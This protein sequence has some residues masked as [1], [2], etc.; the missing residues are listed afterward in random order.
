MRILGQLQELLGGGSAQQRALA[1]AAR[2]NDVDALAKM[3]AS[4]DD[5]QLKE[6]VQR[7]SAEQAPLILKQL[8][9]HRKVALTIALLQQRSLSPAAQNAIA[10]RLT[11][12]ERGQ[13]LSFAGA[14]ARTLE[15]NGFGAGVAA[16]VRATNAADRS[17][18][19]AQ[20][21]V[22]LPP[23]LAQ[24]IAKYDFAPRI[25]AVRAGQIGMGAE[26]KR[27]VRNQLE[28]LDGAQLKAMRELLVERPA[29]PQLKQMA[30]HWALKGPPTMAGLMSILSGE[31]L[32]LV[33]DVSG[34]LVRRAR[35]LIDTACGDQ[36][37]AFKKS[38]VDVLATSELAVHFVEGFGTQALR[39]LSEL[40]L[41]PVEVACGSEW[42]RQHTLILALENAQ[43][44]EVKAWIDRHG[45]DPLGPALT[46]LER[47]SWQGPFLEPGMLIRSMGFERAV[48]FTSLLEDRTLHHGLRA[49]RTLNGFDSEALVRFLISKDEAQIR[50]LCADAA[51]KLPAFGTAMAPL[52]SGGSWPPREMPRTRKTAQ[53]EAAL[54]AGSGIDPE[55]LAKSRKN[56]SSAQLSWVADRMRRAIWE[57]DPRLLEQADRELQGR[58][59]VSFR[60]YD[61]LYDQGVQNPEHRYSVQTFS[62]W[63]KADSLIRERANISR[64]R[65]LA[66]GELLDVMREAHALVGKGM[67]EI[68]ESH[69][70]EA[71]LGV[72][73]SRAEQ[74]VQLGGGSQK[75]GDNTLRILRK[76]PYLQ[77]FLAFE[78][79]VPDEDGKYSR[80]IMFSKGSDVPQLMRELDTWVR[81]NEGK[82]PP[83]SLAAEVHFRLVSIHPFMDGNGRTSKLVADYLLAR[84]GI[85]PPVWR[86]GDVM[87]H[88]DRWAEV[89]RTGVEY[90][91]HT[92][93]RYF[94]HAVEARG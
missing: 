51:Q 29:H 54:L 43:P 62:S 3:V 23:L 81:D 5:A 72:F 9:S 92:V 58:R 35:T 25:A 13:V 67:V 56:Y 38:W 85:R 53:A 17:R 46:A 75:V 61:A 68:G 21:K 73:R 24:F 88:Q 77:Q 10:K 83:E 27:N 66:E 69:L 2:A 7:I 91:L 70:K 64:G 19:L 48:T 40:G 45:A 63:Q 93:E 20:A 36:S 41:A 8:E 34:E 74:H 59:F 84:A 57:H 52:Y 71:D 60:Y 30:G 14:L 89:V 22:S 78:N 47:S 16:D 79:L 49:M 1:A 76:N 15:A 4:A 33:P 26:E 11:P 82:I 32:G 31:P 90:D 87:K 18:L 55:L 12:V 37:A 86:E 50:A 65:P 28:D 39:V 6:L 44:G 94:R 80:F 42:G